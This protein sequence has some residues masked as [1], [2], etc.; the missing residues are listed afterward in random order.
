MKM[1]EGMKGLGLDDNCDR[2][3]EEIDLGE[4]IQQEL[5]QSSTSLKMSLI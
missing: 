5:Q 1:L 3:D 4:T 2:C